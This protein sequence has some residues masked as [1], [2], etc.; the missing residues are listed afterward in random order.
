MSRFPA[1]P[2]ND[3]RVFSNVLNLP[4]PLGRAHVVSICVFNADTGLR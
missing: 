1:H 3:G 2:V 4:C